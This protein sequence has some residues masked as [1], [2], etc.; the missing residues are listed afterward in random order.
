[1]STSSEQP[2][3]NTTPEKPQIYKKLVQRVSKGKVKN[4]PTFT[5]ILQENNKFLFKKNSPKKTNSPKKKFN[6]RPHLKKKESLNLS[7][8]N[9]KRFSASIRELD[10]NTYRAFK[11]SIDEQKNNISKNN[12]ST[13]EILNNQHNI[14]K[15]P[16]GLKSKRFDWQTGIE[17]NYLDELYGNNKNYAK[18]KKSINWEGFL[19]KE[20][21]DD[22]NNI[23][24][25]NY[26]HIYSTIINLNSKRTI[27]PQR[28]IIP[29]IKTKASKKFINRSSSTGSIISLF[30]RTPNIKNIPI[31]ENITK[32]NNL[33]S[34][35]FF[36]GFFFKKSKRSVDLDKFKKN[37]YAGLTKEKK[38]D[39]S[40]LYKNKNNNNFYHYGF[41]ERIKRE[42]NDLM[43]KKNSRNIN[44]DLYNNNDNI[45]HFTNE[46]KHSQLMR[47]K[48]NISDI[49]FIKG[50]KEKI[51][52]NFKK[53]QLT[54]TFDY[55]QNQF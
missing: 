2:K 31:N 20:T 42:K 11:M 18:R 29:E 23:K 35:E 4:L 37:G 5:E 39:D 17:K 45:I 24:R 15:V 3:D 32:G 38:S 12:K 52:Q 49:F 36:N 33:F 28:D 14:T 30:N 40:F 46:L 13:N 26:A 22:I 43:Y 55:S 27:E 16:F 47:I 44:F 41:K 10:Y 54:Y 25:N 51:F 34:D 8:Q 21:N 9:Q 7:S 50:G 1:M 53:N 48:N 19:N 6:Q